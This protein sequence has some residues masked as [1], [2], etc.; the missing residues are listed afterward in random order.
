MKLFFLETRCVTR[1]D[2]SFGEISGRAKIKKKS[3][4]PKSSA[5]ESA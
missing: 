3:E 1:D 5:L 2:L 4:I